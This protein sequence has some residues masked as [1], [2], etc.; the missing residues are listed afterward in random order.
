MIPS[1]FV[2]LESLP[3]NPNGKVNR[4][5]LP[6]PE[7]N[8]AE[9]STFV[10]PR[11]AIEEILAGIW[12]EILR[13]ERVGIDDNFFELG[14]HSLLATQI[15]TRIRDRLKVELPF[16]RILEFPT[17]AGLALK[18]EEVLQQEQ[19][20]LGIALQPISRNQRIPLSFS[21]KQLWF[22]A[23]V[24]PNIPV[25]NEPCTIRF[26]GAID[27]DALEKALNAIINRHESLRTR[28]MA[29]DGQPV[30]V[31]ENRN[32]RQKLCDWRK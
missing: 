15:I 31:I 30:M 20:P 9:L 12:A 19:R 5:A 3:L 24:E 4:R 26:P 8:P 13:V 18:V 25:Y 22:L 14:G 29:V 17:V 2:V 21:Q 10:A 1:H 7:I 32:G 23:Q 27:V 28:F 11:T 6:K 16:S